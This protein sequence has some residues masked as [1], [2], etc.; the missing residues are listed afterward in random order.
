MEA[1]IGIESKECGVE[2]KVVEGSMEEVEFEQQ[3]L[4]WIKE[5]CSRQKQRTPPVG[6]KQKLRKTFKTSTPGKPVSMI[7]SAEHLLN[8]SRRRALKK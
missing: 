1:A 3:R 6:Q 8:H 2:R 7:Y 4:Q 5:Y